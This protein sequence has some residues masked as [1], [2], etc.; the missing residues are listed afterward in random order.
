MLAVTIP[1]AAVIDSG[2]HTGFVKTTRSRRPDFTIAH[3][4][5]HGIYLIL[6]CCRWFFGNEIDSTTD[7]ATSVNGRVGSAGEFNFFQS[8]MI[9][10]NQR[11]MVKNT[12]GANGN[13]IFKIQEHTFVTDGLPNR[14]RM[15]F[16]AQIDHHHARGFV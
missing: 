10:F 11:I 6:R 15:L 4:V 16:V 3:V 8:G 2:K 14:H 1:S 13:P 7:S 9:D 12:G 5:T